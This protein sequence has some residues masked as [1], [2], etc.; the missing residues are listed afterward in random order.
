MH[1]QW[2]GRYSGTNDGLLVVDL[3]DAGDC[4][5]GSACALD[6]NAQLPPTFADLTRTPIP[7]GKTE[8]ELTV[9]LMPIDRVTGNV[10][11]WDEVKNSYPSGVAVATYAKLIGRSLV[12]KSPSRGPPT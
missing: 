12:T 3:D 9:Q 6:S 11:S 1:G 5:D 7:K 2:I 10:A 8:F 4:F